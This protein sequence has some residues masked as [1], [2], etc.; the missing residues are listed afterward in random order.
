MNLVRRAAL[1]TIAAVTVLIPAGTSYAAT[2]DVKWTQVHDRLLTALQARVHTLATLT[3][4]VNNDKTLT[5]GDKSTLTSLLAGETSGIQQLLTQVQAATPQNTAVP[6][7]RADATEMVDQYRVYLVMARQVHLTEAAD[8]ET[9]IETN[10]ENRES[11]IQ[12]AIE[13]AGSPPSGV[14]AYNDLVA[15]VTHATQATGDANIPAVLAVTP[16]GYPADAG[17]LTSARSSLGQ[18]RTDLETARGDLMAIRN[19]LQQHASTANPSA[20]PNA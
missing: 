14:Q 2:G 20:V 9:A 4:S 17:P 13:K 1:G 15:H 16:Q 11:R 7:L 3:S 8:R 5:P 19:A 10:L 12:A 18:A 6:Q